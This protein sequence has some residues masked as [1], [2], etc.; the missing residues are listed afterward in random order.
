M[1]FIIEFFMGLKWNEGPWGVSVFDP[2]GYGDFRYRSNINFN[3]VG[4]WSNATFHWSIYSFHKH[5]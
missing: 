4:L 5:S 2:N 1:G 3:E